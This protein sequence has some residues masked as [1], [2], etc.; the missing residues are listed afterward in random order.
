MHHWLPVKHMLSHIQ[1][2][3]VCPLC[4]HADETLDHI[5]HCPHPVLAVKC[6]IGS[7]LMLSLVFCLL[8]SRGTTLLL[9]PILSSL[10]Y[11]QHNTALAFIC[12]HE[13]FSHCHGSTLWQPWI[14]PTLTASYPL[15]PS[16]YGP[17]SQIHFG[18]K[19]TASPITLQTLI[20][21]IQSTTLTPKIS[22][23][24]FLAR[25]SDWSTMM[26]LT[27]WTLSLPKFQDNSFLPDLPT[28]QKCWYWPFGRYPFAD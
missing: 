21:D 13:V 4:A 14:A 16:V 2:S 5:F 20:T 17:P 3:P 8:I 11:S 28:D 12:Y 23:Q 9:R 15:S 22:G 27:I 18:E 19:E 25:P 1:G 6:K 7:L 10:I 24:F 26:T